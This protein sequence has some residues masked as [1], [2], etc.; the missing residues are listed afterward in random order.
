M[1]INF[2][3]NLIS[4][5]KSLDKPLY[6]VGGVVRNFLIDGS[7]SVDVDLASANTAEQLIEKL[8]DFGF[9]VLAEYKRTGTVVFSDKN[10]KYEYTS[11]RRESYLSGGAH[12]P[13]KVE[14]TS[15]MK[16][17]AL[18]RDFTCNALYCDVITG[19][20]F[21]PLGKGV[22]DVEEKRLDTVTDPEKVFCSDGLRLMRLARFSAELD[23]TPTEDV[24]NSAKM[25]ADNIKDISPERIYAELNKILCAD[26][27]YP[28]SNKA[29]HYQGIKI[30]DQTRVLDR[31]FP[32]LAKGRG[33]AQRAD[34]HNF[35]VLEHGLKCLLYAPKNIR[36]A[37]LL[38]DV[39]KAE[40]MEVDKNFYR[41]AE[42]G[43]RKAI[44][45]L[46][47]LKADKKTI[48]QVA[49]LTKWHMLDM[50]G[51]MREQKLRLF[52][53]KNARYFEDLLSIKQAD[54]KACKE[55]EGTAKTVEKWLALMDKMKG[56]GTPFSLKDLKISANDLM[57][58]GYRG[59]E[60][61]KELSSLFDF[62]VCNAKEN[63]RERL[64]NRAKKD[65][66]R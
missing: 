55:Q 36:L 20:I 31:I 38:H 49:F 18:R 8:G 54:Y 32:D 34:Y 2:S 22:A 28:F 64:L 11:F 44:T 50:D 4:L 15:D 10:Q 7:F 13:D 12:T 63:E 41:H 33:M 3:K 26:E 14:Y 19:E 61:G 9:D 16:E 53:V 35:D 48:E 66:K 24:L 57:E 52:F 21:D 25:Y 40:C 23:F 60:I 17:D 46:K 45:A 27:R 59:K 1:K 29:G 42:V 43:E 62:A 30:L 65:Y 6:A 51:K 56:D 5:A 58:I 37:A 39:G 47:R